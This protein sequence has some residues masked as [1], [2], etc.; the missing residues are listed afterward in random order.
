MSDVFDLRPRIGLVGAGLSESISA[1]ERVRDVVLTASWGMTGRWREEYD[2]ADARRADRLLHLLGVADLAERRFGTLS[3]GE[4][5]RSLIARALM[6]DPELLLLDEPARGWISAGASNWS[7]ACRPWPWIPPPPRPCWSP[8]T[9]KRFR[10][11]SRTH[12]SCATAGPSPRVRLRRC[13]SMRRCPPPT[14]CRLRSNVATGDGRLEPY[15][16]PGQAAMVLCRPVGPALHRRGSRRPGS[17][18]PPH[19]VA[20]GVRLPS[21]PPAEGPHRSV[22]TSSPASELG[23]APATSPRRPTAPPCAKSTHRSPSSIHLVA[24]RAFVRSVAEEREV[25]IVPSRGF[26][27]SEKDFARWADGRRHL[28]QEDFYREARRR[29]GILM[30]GSEP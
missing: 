7:A 27:T 5:K 18:R 8:T 12:S 4:R 29:T 2:A 14:A 24:A 16:R 3:D 19:R 22:G 9:W 21:L 17:T 11:A 28:R 20:R 6:S 30:E 25:D 1:R 15:E 23:I 13:W 10:S 26:V